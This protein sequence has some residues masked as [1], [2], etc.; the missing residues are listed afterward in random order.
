MVVAFYGFQRVP[1]VRIV[2]PAGRWQGWFDERAAPLIEAGISDHHLHN[3]FGLHK[4]DGRGERV[5]HIDQ[6]ELSFCQGLH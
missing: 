1:D 5:M 3:P 2:T 6:F 4:I